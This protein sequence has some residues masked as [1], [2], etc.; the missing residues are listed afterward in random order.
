MESFSSEGSFRD[1]IEFGFFYVKIWFPC[2]TCQQSP[3][4]AT[5]FCAKSTL[6]ILNHLLYRRNS[7]IL[8]CLCCM[9][10]SFCLVIFFCYRYRV[11]KATFVLFLLRILEEQFVRVF[12]VRLQM[13]RFAS[14]LGWHC[15]G[16][17]G[18]SSFRADFVIFPSLLFLH[19]YLG[20]SLRVSRDRKFDI[21]LFIWNARELWSQS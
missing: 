2:G 15:C 14:L 10:W 4:C 3:F 18:R 21:F 17:L 19:L 9:A 20:P 12:L 8:D 6:I 1:G 13:S 11:R 16:Y 5:V 7:F